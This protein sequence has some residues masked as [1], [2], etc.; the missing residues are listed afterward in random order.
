MNMNV[1]VLVLAINVLLGSIENLW[2]KLILEDYNDRMIET[3]LAIEQN[4]HDPHS[5][6]CATANHSF[7]WDE[8]QGLR[9]LQPTLRAVSLTMG[10]CRD[11]SLSFSSEIRFYALVRRVV[12]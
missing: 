8:L 3:Q 6:V 10:S 1:L 5:R 2:T 7:K 11:Q 9:T 4:E 12:S